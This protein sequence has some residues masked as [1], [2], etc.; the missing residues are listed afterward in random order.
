MDRQLS[1][2]GRDYP[3][4]SYEFNRRLH[5]C[6]AKTPKQDDEQLQKAIDKAEFIKKEVEALI[7][8][9]KYRHRACCRELSQRFRQ[10]CLVPTRLR[11]KL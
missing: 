1:W 2:L 10:Q 7:F 5:A 8:L 9:K 11:W 4:P 6:F 3:D